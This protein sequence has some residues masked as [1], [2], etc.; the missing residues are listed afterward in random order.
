MKKVLLPVLLFG[1]LQVTIAQDVKKVETNVM[2][3]KWEDAKTEVDKAVLDPKNQGKPDAWYW[4]SR[5]YAE[6]A[7]DDA[8]RA[9]YPTLIAD[10]EAAF[11]KYEEMDPTLALVKAKGND[12][13]FAMYAATL[14]V[15]TAIFNDKSPTKKWEDAGK[16]FEKANDYVN[17]IIKNQWTNKSLVF[18]TTTVLY[19]GYA[20]QNAQ[21]P[22]KASQYYAFLADNKVKGEG[23]DE[24]YKYL[25]LHYVNTKNEAQFNKYIAVAREVYPKDDS[26]EEFEVLYMDKN[27]T[28]DEKIAAYDKG[29]AAGTLS[30]MKYLQFGDIF[31]KAKNTDGID[32]AKQ[33][34]YT[35]KAADAFKKAYGKNKQNAIAAFNAGVIYYNVYV[36]YDDKYAANIRE[37]QRIN[38]DKPVEKD[39]KKKAAAEAAVKAK[40]DPIRAAN[41]NIEKPL[42]ENLD[43]ALEWLEKS[44]LALKDKSN[45]TGVEKSVISK[46]VDFLANLYAYKRDKMRGKDDKAYDAYDAKYKEYDALHGKF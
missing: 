2:L 20:Y 24:L 3:G 11:K 12:G 9:K 40:V 46:D 7:K 39:P 17:F 10:A 31:I 32:S 33:Q 21:M 1:I 37:M 13:Y 26:W 34:F 25:A 43:I 30:E 35:L 45:K 23:Y 42:M 44:Y 15:G 16:S 22:E 29:D 4:K 36:D 19:A 28:L 18:D 27:L 41:L 6:M 5:I 38:A 14:K 8:S